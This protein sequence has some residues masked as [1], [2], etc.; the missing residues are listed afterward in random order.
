[1]TGYRHKLWL[2]ATLISL[3]GCAGRDPF[4]S[5]HTYRPIVP[6][7]TAALLPD[8][9]DARYSVEPPRE[10]RYLSQ[11]NAAL[12]KLRNTISPVHQPPSAGSLHESQGSLAT[13][14]S[15][16]RQELSS[17]AGL[18]PTADRIKPASHLSPASSISTGTLN[19]DGRTYKVQLVEEIDSAGQN[20]NRELTAVEALF[21][22]ASEVT[23]LP[24][25]HATDNFQ[26]TSLTTVTSTQPEDAFPL[27]LPTALEMVGGQHPAVGFAQWKVQEAY[28]RLDKAEALWLP[29][30]QTGFSFHRHDGNYQAS[31][32]AIV[33]VNRNA[34]QLGLGAGGVGAG[35]TPRP[36]VV[37]QFHLADAMF[38]PEIAQKEA[39]AKGHS[40]N[41]VYN[42]QLLDTATAYLELLRAEQDLRVLED[43]LV[44]TTELAKLTKD[45][46]ETG[47]GLRADANRLE[48]EQALLESRIVEARESAATASARLCE[49]LSMNARR[50]VVPLDPTVTPIDLIST[51]MEKSSLISTGLANRPELK[52]AQ[53][54][55]AATCDQFN[56]QKYAPFVPSVLLG[57]SAGG[58]GGGT[59]GNLGNFDERVD[60]DAMMTWEIRNLGFGEHASRRETR[61]KI[62]QA[63]FEKVRKL[64]E[65]AREVSEAHTQVTHRGSRIE[66]TQAAVQ[67]AQASFEQNVSRIRDG[68]GLPIEALQSVKALEDARRAYLNAVVD[69]NQAQFQLQWSLGWPVL[70]PSTQE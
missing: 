67:F 59:G 17:S 70:A 41:G 30:L 44:Q 39:W 26:T 32:G 54:L 22:N 35:T 64:D 61:A 42:R 48:T 10:T 58:Y 47:Q 45:F 4:V 14:Q 57:F 29:S 3:A 62:E 11:D 36:G 6:E 38:Q 50:R 13:Y 28:A 12:A 66:K 23:P 18:L 56:R 68:Q 33:D 24:R 65:V 25:D 5:D 1:M 69:Y 16:A 63:K 2:A 20:R 60:F 37:A 7:S 46:A 27:D 40:A 15:E 31:N 52:E 55:V 8:G 9:S 34:F 51:D 43:S 53:A 19:V 49:A 21:Q